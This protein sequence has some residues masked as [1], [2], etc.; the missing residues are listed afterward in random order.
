M[1]IYRNLHFSKSQTFSYLKLNLHVDERPKMSCKIGCMQPRNW[2][3]LSEKS[4]SPPSKVSLVVLFM[5][6]I[7]LAK[8]TR[9]QVCLNTQ[10]KGH[11]LVEL[12]WPEMSRQDVTHCHV[13]TVES[14]LGVWMDQT[15]LQ[16][17]TADVSAPARGKREP[18][19][20]Q[21]SS[22]DWSRITSTFIPSGANSSFTK[23]C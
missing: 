4:K 11:A 17:V 12:T 8:P 14:A 23:L 13:V 3:P 19:H 21:L 22:T 15:K 9:I 7:T 1:N 6:V 18:T 20:C 5:Y 16:N 10:T 2:H